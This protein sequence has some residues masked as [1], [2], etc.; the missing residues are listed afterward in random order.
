MV[1]EAAETNVVVEAKAVVGLE[2]A[3]D[4]AKATSTVAEV[5]PRRHGCDWVSQQQGQ[6]GRHCI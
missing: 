5:S 4:A 1:V 6:A 2:V 3:V